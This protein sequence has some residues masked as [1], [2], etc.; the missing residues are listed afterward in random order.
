MAGIRSA[1]NTLLRGW[2]RRYIPRQMTRRLSVARATRVGDAEV[3]V[4]LGSQDYLD[5]AYDSAPVVAEDAYNMAMDMT[6]NNGQAAIVEMMYGDFY[7]A[8]EISASE[9]SDL[10]AADYLLFACP[11]PEAVGEIMQEAGQYIDDTMSEIRAE[12]WLE[13]GELESSLEGIYS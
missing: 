4:D 9:Y 13:L 7:A 1:E 12:A 11:H 10:S 5:A 3:E 8:A 2:Q 6:V